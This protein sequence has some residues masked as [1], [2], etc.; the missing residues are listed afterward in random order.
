MMMM[1]M[2]IWGNLGRLEVG[3]RKVACW[4]TKAAISLNARRHRGL[5]TK[6]SQWKAYR[7]SPTLFRTVSSSTPYG[8][9]FP[10]IGGSQPPPK[11][12]IAIVSGTDEAIWQ[13]HYPLPASI[14][15]KVH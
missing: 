10:K 12:P 14:G 5:K 13:E 6:K 1:M 4:S 8:F 9:L 3:W 11:T 7:N 15:T 2:I